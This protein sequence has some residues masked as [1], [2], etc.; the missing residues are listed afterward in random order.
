MKTYFKWYEFDCIKHKTLE[1]I[2]MLS[3]HD[4]LFCCLSRCHLISRHQ[5]AV[6]IDNK[7]YYSSVNICYCIVFLYISD[8][9]Y[10]ILCGAWNMSHQN[11]DRV[12]TKVLGSGVISSIHD[13]IL[14]IIFPLCFNLFAHQ[15]HRRNQSLTITLKAWKYQQN[16][17]IGVFSLRCWLI[18]LTAVIKQGF[19]IKIAS[20]CFLRYWYEKIRS[21]LKSL[22]YITEQ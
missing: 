18:K 20:I 8:I 6:I 7:I 14:F 13:W 22:V 2:I 21:Y 11:V 3:I 4:Y 9:I 10:T 12:E 16:R 17:T 5:R 1:A 15:N 19:L